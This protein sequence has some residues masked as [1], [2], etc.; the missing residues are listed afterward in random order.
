MAVD[1]GAPQNRHRRI[2]HRAVDRGAPQDRHCGITDLA[3]DRRAAQDRDRCVGLLILAH[4]GVMAD[5]HLLVVC[6]RRSGVLVHRLPDGLFDLAM[7]V[8]G[9]W[10]RLG[11]EAG[12]APWTAVRPPRFP[13]PAHR[14]GTPP[15]WRSR[16]LVRPVPRRQPG[17][18]G[19]SGF[20][21]SAAGGG[22]GLSV[23]RRGGRRRIFAAGDG[24]Q[25][26]AQG[27]RRHPENRGDGCVS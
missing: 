12:A 5:G 6:A 24:R 2:P 15:G 16:R 22:A 13:W 18:C 8:T 1:R 23:S 7:N 21:G 26:S 27:R 19:V 3:V 25:K 9:G 11:V 10:R 14:P 4:M 17:R 20:A